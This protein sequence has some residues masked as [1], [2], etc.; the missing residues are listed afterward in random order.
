MVIAHIPLT[1]PV[2]MR[3]IGKTT[4]MYGALSAAYVFGSRM[5]GSIRNKD[6]FV[7]AGVGGALAGALMGVYKGNLL[8]A[9]NITLAMGIGMAAAVYLYVVYLYSV[10]YEC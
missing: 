4:M 1:I 7:N 8:V 10:A 9:T 2:Q 3:V 5:S 6:D